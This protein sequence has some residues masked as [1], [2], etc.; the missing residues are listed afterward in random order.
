MIVFI[1][2][3]VKF[4]YSSRYIHFFA[5]GVTAVGLNL[6]V[7]VGFTELFFGREQYFSAYLI[8]LT[9]S[10]LYSFTMHTVVT[11][12]TSSD[13]F[14]RLVYFA[15][16]SLSLAYVQALLVKTI[17]SIVGIDWYATVI[18]AVILSL[19]IMTFVIFKFF[20]FKEVGQISGREQQN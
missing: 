9:V 12:K 1:E 2:R 6:G 16:Y 4:L 11:F 10:L 15:A 14:K 20:M 3:V 13:H 19:S 5:V 18:A 7:T 17:T 8:G